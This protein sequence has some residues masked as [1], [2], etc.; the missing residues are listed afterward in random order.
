[1]DLNQRPSIELRGRSEPAVNCLELGFFN[2][3]EICEKLK[4]SKKTV[5]G[6]KKGSKHQL[7]AN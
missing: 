6:T 7:L 2:K 1:M 3:I 4:D 5:I